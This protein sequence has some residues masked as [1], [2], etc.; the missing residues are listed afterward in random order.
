MMAR[1]LPKERSVSPPRSP[2][3]VLTPKECVPRAPA[4]SARS[5]IRPV[6]ASEM[7]TA[8]AEAQQHEDRPKAPTNRRSLGDMVIRTLGFVGKIVGQGVVAIA[9][10]FMIP[11]AASTNFIANKL[12]GLLMTGTKHFWCSFGAIFSL[13]TYLT[14][15]ICTGVVAIPK[16][17]WKACTGDKQQQQLLQMSQ[18]L[19]DVRQR[20]EMRRRQLDIGE[21]IG[22]AISHGQHLH[23]RSF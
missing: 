8:I 13:F 1:T 6:D 7:R 18:R 17:V 16:K 4:S 11:M 10:L 2:G 9:C 15:E 5:R 22:G 19:D 14:A 23:G 3:C 20:Q 12:P 21:A